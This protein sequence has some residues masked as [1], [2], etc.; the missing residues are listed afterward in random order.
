MSTSET[1]H[2]P[3][4]ER[5]VIEALGADK[6]GRFLDCTLGGGGHTQ[7]I[8]NVNR[9]NQ[10]VACDRDAR[11]IERAKLRLSKEQARITFH[12]AAFSELGAVLPQESFNGMLADLGLSTD[13]IKESRG[14]SYGD[15]TPL[16]MRM[17]E[18][19]T[20]SAY[21]VV[22]EYSESELHRALKRGGVGA[23]AKSVVRAILD[24]RPIQT[25]AALAALIRGVYARRPFDKKIDPATVVFQA[26]RIEVNN[27]FGQIEE[28]LAFA[29][30]HVK[31]GG[32]LAVITFHSLED[33]LVTRTMRDWEARGSE[34]LHWPG[35]KDEKRLGRVLTRKPTLAGDEEI[36]ANPSARSARL[37]VFEFD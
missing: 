5:E 2:I 27:E 7:A 10:V 15:E 21:Q 8:L 4:L 3:V 29:P 35:R 32:R 26:I 12:H 18:E 19:Q 13:Q 1:C 31:S 28:L 25:T 9:E 37:R 30:T 36:A 16:D 20:G 34:P 17:D 33:K 6:G 22:N 11:A 24:H 14:F 23:E